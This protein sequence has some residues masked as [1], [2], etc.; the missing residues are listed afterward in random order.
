MF[1]LYTVSYILLWRHTY[2]SGIVWTDTLW[3]GMTKAVPVVH[4]SAVWG[5]FW[6]QNRDDYEYHPCYWCFS[7]ETCLNARISGFSILE[8]SDYITSFLK[9]NRWKCTTFKRESVP[10]KRCLGTK[11]VPKVTF[12][13]WT[14][15][16]SNYLFGMVFETEGKQSGIL[17]TGISSRRELISPV[18]FFIIIW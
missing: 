14:K 13:V 18:S 7:L 2:R 6:G 8:Q 12:H 5:S 16:L 10:S 4:I 15:T 17:C 9:S 11:I 3:K 1:T